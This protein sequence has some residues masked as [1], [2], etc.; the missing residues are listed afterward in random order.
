MYM[1]I[2]PQSS[3]RWCSA[4]SNNALRRRRLDVTIVV[5]EGLQAHTGQTIAKE[6]VD[7]LGIHFHLV[8]VQVG[9]DLSRR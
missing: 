5:E 7:I 1:W 4:G 8:G 9:K 6:A 3:G 2:R